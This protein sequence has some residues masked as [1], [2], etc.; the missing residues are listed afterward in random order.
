MTGARCLRGAAALVLILWVLIAS[1]CAGGISGAAARSA[2]PLDGRAVPVAGNR[3]FVFRT[4]TE[5]MLSTP[6]TVIVRLPG[7]YTDAGFAQDNSH[8]YALDDSGVLT[9]V[10]VD[11]GASPRRIECRCKRIFPLHHTVIGWWREPD[12]FVQADLRDLNP[13][14]RLTVSLPPPERVEPGAVVSSPRLLAAGERTLILDQVESTPGASWS[15]NHLSLVDTRTGVVRRLGPV[16]GINTA[17]DRAVLRPDGQAAAVYGYIRDGIACG[18]AR[19]LHIDLVRERLERL[20]LPTVSGCSALADLRWD[21]AALTVTDVVWESGSP[22]RFVTAVW[23][24][25]AMRWERRGGDDTLR[26]GALT[27]AVALEVRRTGHAQGH[28]AHT[29]DLTLTAVGEMQV[30]AHDVLDI[31]L[32]HV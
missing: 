8:I 2:S 21:A 23:D 10:R 1:G 28:G 17:L 29:G 6:E 30:L 18:A 11:R 20:D 3:Q 26:Y 24:R 14:V 4:R 22:D 13:T 27:P 32:P 15:I 19:L 5:L 31:R 12:S 25:P 9:T 7:S 16:D